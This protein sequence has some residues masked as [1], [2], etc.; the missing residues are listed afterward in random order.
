MANMALVPYK[1]VAKFHS[2]IRAYLEQHYGLPEQ[3]VLDSTNIDKY[4]QYID[5]ILYDIDDF[6][7][8]N[9][10]AP[11][12]KLKRLDLDLSGFTIDDIY[13]ELLNLD[14]RKLSQEYVIEHGAVRYFGL[15]INNVLSAGYMRIGHNKYENQFYIQF[16]T[17]FC[18]PSSKVLCTI[19]N[20]LLEM[21]TIYI[22]HGNND[23]YAIF[24]M[25]NGD[26]IKDIRRYFNQHRC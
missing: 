5:K 10:I 22:A 2:K 25:A 9:F 26:S 6:K 4:Q 11:D 3:I 18:F 23:D 14:F 12:G 7:R 20:I 16:D 21:D 17:K 15:D 24:S 1:I 19:E 8:A 13:Q